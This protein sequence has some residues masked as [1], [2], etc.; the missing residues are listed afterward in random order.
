MIFV[1]VL[2]KV[3]DSFF[4][5]NFVSRRRTL[6]NRGYAASCRIKRLEQKSDL[7]QEKGKEFKDLDFVQEDN[8]QMREEIEDL[9]KKFEALKRF[10]QQKKI[11][12]PPELD[13]Y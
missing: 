3:N 7:E 4:T 2:G 10:S 9:H 12:I 5:K 6:K 13:Q 1:T 8:A 11:G